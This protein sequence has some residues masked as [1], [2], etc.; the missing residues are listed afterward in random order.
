MSHFEYLNTFVS[1]V[2]AIMVGR[3]LVTLS[4]VTFRKISWLHVAWLVVLTFNMLQIWWL[5]WGFNDDQGYNYFDYLLLL[6]PAFAL[7][8]AVAV[9]TPSDEPADWSEFFQEKRVQFF[10]SY[11]VFWLTL[12]GSHL[13]Y[14]GNWNGVA[15]PVLFCA[16]G[17]AIKNL[18][19]QYVLV[20]FFISIFALRAYRLGM[21]G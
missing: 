3:T 18:Y 14:G 10:S 2:F 21:G 1:F 11:G 16:L 15:V 12:I 20:V 4:D 19:F 5:R 6:G 13:Y 7:A 8:F 17:A 9:L